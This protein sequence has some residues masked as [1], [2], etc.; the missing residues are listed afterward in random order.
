MGGILLLAGLG[1][2]IQ[3]DSFSKVLIFDGVPSS[4]SD[5]LLYVVIVTEGV[6]AT[7]LI[8]GNGGRIAIQAIAG[9][10]ACYT[11]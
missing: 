7:L 3:H 11:V 8:L 10:F 6:L 9:L 1:K 2:A 4:V 5:Y